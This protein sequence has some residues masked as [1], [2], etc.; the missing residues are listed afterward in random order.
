[1]KIPNRETVV[2]AF[3]HDGFIIVPRVLSTE[4]IARAMKEL[5]PSIEKDAAPA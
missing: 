1:M 2:R 5:A 4:Y 3:D